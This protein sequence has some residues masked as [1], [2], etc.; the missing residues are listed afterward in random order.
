MST[1]LFR[2]VL[3]SRCLSNP[4][5]D[6]I[7][8]LSMLDIS[9][10]E[11]GS[12][13]KH[14]MDDLP[15]PSLLKQVQILRLTSVHKTEIYNADLANPVHPNQEDT[16]TS[17]LQSLLKNTPNLR[18]L[19]LSTIG[20]PNLE[21]QT[22]FKSCIWLQLFDLTLSH[23]CIDVSGFETFLSAHASCLKELR[24][25]YSKLAPTG[26][27]HAWIELLK[28]TKENMDLS[29]LSLGCNLWEDDDRVFNSS[30]LH[31]FKSGIIINI[32]DAARFLVCGKYLS[33]EE[34]MRPLECEFSKLT[35]QDISAA[36]R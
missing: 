8:P 27:Q 5:G 32:G 15:F 30:A 25:S 1:Q 2:A 4:S 9:N 29:E 33:N 19:G 28:F 13:Y 16:S 35:W 7:S 23:F 24:I 6:G 21:I 3:A 14:T 10:T 12:F 11:L 26:R 18:S 36:Y 31:R 20:Q 22:V 34:L 17:L